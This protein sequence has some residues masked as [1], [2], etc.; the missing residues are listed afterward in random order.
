MKII[1]PKYYEN[2]KCIADKCRHTCCAHWEIDIDEETLQKYEET[3]GSLGLKLKNNIA[4]DE[5]PHF[6]FK[7]DERCPF[8]NENNLCE[9]ILEKGEEYLSQV[10]TDHPRFRSYFSDRIEIGLG[11]CCEEAARLILESKNKLGLYTISDDGKNEELSQEEEFILNARELAFQIA[12][13]ESLS[14]KERIEELLLTF[15][16]KLPEKSKKEWAEYFLSLARLDEAWEERL[17]ELKSLESKKDISL[18]SYD[19]PLS[20]LLTYFLYR[21]VP[22]SESCEDVR[23]QIAFSILS[24]EIIGELF[25]ISLTKGKPE[26]LA[27]ISRLYSSE[28]EYSEINTEDILNMLWD[29]IN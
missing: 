17:N 25:K 14:I 3:E 9:I 15:K 23:T 27:E 18:S 22:L 29:C 21:H 10:C 6:I 19:M 2:F 13:D 24:A 7:D 1:A 20:R 11:L 8:L 4:F 12:K 16:I 5:C 26:D 28:I